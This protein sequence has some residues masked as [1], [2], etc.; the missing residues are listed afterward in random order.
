MDVK[1]QMYSEYN[2]QVSSANGIKITDSEKLVPNLLNKN[3]YVVHI[4]TLKLYLEL[5]MKITKVHK[6][7][8]FNQKPW[9]KEYVELC[10][11]QRKI[12]KKNGNDFLST[13]F[14]L[15]MN[16]VFGKTMENVRKRLNFYLKTE[17]DNLNKT[18]ADPKLQDIIPF[19]KDLV[20][21]QMRK[22]SVTLNKPIYTGFAILD[23]SKEHMYNFHYNTMKKK[24]G[25]NIKL[26]FTDTD[27]LCYHI[28][29]ENIIDDLTSIK[30]DFDFGEYPDGHVLKD[31]TNLS[32]LGKMKDEMKSLE[33]LE[34]VGL[35]PKMYA[36][37]DELDKEK[38]VAKGVKKCQH[39]K[40][41][42]FKNCVFNG[43]TTDV[44]QETF[45]SN[46]HIVYSL[47]QTK[48]ALSPVDT[49]RWIKDDGIY[50][51]AHG[52]KDIPNRNEIYNI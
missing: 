41:E 52:H 30:D 39:P 5:G 16:A 47:T 24:F 44:T 6:V 17:S 28:T 26:L 20:G 14:K 48:L 27:S 8:S 4:S 9:L 10:A 25:D 32:V 34:F 23:L 36:L 7:I 49:K 18:F 46:K 31:E 29:T 15:A 22:L 3:N 50:S 21:V 45:R 1:K 2:K 35:K 42:A 43:N 19:S 51:F 13:I 12:A 37:F 40:F 38:I 33:I 11:L